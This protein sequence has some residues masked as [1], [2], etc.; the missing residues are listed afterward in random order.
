M[1]SSPTPRPR[2]RHTLLAL[3][4]A[5][6]IGLSGCSATHTMVK[7]RNLD[8]QTK[9]SETVFLEPVAS[10]KRVI[11]ID[12][13]NTSDKD[14]P[15]LD[16]IKAV[17]SERGYRIADAPEKANF[18]LQGNVLH[19]GRTDLR[20]A[21]SALDA[22]FGGAVA[23][24]TLAYAGGGDSARGFA[25]AGLLGAA[26]GIVGDALVDDVVFSMITDLQIRE[27]PLAGEVVTQQ[28][29]TNAQQGGAT[30]LEQ[31]VSG[32]T[33]NWKTYRTRIVSTANKVNLKFEEAQPELMSGLV[34]SIGG[35]F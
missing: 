13:R 7:K 19:V 3:C 20:T 34:R 26:A 5:S 22:G 23:A 29:A 27:R 17:L 14:L 33:V 32:A 6:L 12:M 1:V 35:V 9:M 4:T 10:D 11:F 25:Q 8:V 16:N 18:M 2:M 21:Q 24:A 31:H 30:K 15:I 28:Q